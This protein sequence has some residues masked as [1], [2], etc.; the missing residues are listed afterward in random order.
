MCASGF[1]DFAKCNVTMTQFLETQYISFLPVFMTSLVVSIVIVMTRAKHIHRTAKGHGGL[2]IQ[3]AHDAPTPR[4][5]GAAVLAGLFVGAYFSQDMH[6]G[7]L[8]YGLLAAVP[9][10]LGGFMEDTGF[11]AS[12]KIVFLP[13]CSVA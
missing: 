7:L 5:G 10:F 12:P 4:I 2:A 9:V 3:S 13:P 11:H 1:I 6:G 8:W